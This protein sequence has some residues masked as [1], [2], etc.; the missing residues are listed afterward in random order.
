MIAVSKIRQWT[1]LRNNSNRGFI[2][3]DFDPR[4][5]IDAIFNRYIPTYRNCPRKSK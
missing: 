5:L 3:R 4:D 2:R 1:H